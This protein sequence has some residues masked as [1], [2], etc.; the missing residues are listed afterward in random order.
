[1]NFKPFTIFSDLF[2]KDNNNNN[3][4]NKTSLYRDILFYGLRKKETYFRVYEL[5]EWLIENNKEFNI[6]F[7]EYTAK[8]KDKGKS[9]FIENRVERVKNSIENL[10]DLGLIEARQAK[11]TKGDASTTEYI[12]TVFGQFVTLFIAYDQGEDSTKEKHVEEIFNFF[13]NYFKT[14]PISSNNLFG[15]EYF[16]KCK[17]NNLFKEHIENIL[18]S[19]KSYPDISNENDFFIK[20][21]TINHVKT[22]KRLWLLWKS[23]LNVFNNN[24]EK[25]FYFLHLT[26]LQLQ[27]TFDDKVRNFSKYE[28]Y[29][30]ELRKEPYTVPVQYFCADCNKFNYYGINVIKYIDGLYLDPS[31]LS[32]IKCN[33]C[34]KGNLYF[35]TP[36]D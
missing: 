4:N 32:D 26:K 23:S 27:R 31:I 5:T 33:K 12:L 35:L 18:R 24:P 30:F 11:A 10:V 14:E 8:N 16:K 13:E 3:L 15:L 19:F 21:S 22:S 7:T 20:L 9:D 1:L 25:L 28:I 34:K 29:R 36:Y 6:K 2:R 17:E